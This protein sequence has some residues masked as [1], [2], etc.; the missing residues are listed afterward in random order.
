[1]W[2]TEYFSTLKIHYWY[3][4]HV[5][6]NMALLISASEHAAVSWCL[7]DIPEMAPVA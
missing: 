6:V 5:T 1:M 2:E 7:P 3:E 4:Q